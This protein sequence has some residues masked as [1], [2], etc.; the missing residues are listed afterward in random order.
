VESDPG[1]GS[2]FTVRLLQGLVIGAN[3]LGKDLTKKIGQLRPG[4]T[5]HIKKSPVIHEYMP[6]G[7]VLVVDD[8][9]TNL[10]VTRGLLT[11]YGLSV[12]TASSGYEAVEKVK[13]GASWDIIF[14]DHY[15]PGLDGIEAA[16]IIRGLGYKKHIVAL[17]ANVLTGQAEMFFANGFD[18][19]ISKPIDVRQLNAVLNKLIRDKYPIETVE[20][21]RK[22]KSSMGKSSAPQPSANSEIAKIFTRDAEKSIAI[23]EAIHEKRYNFTDE[24]IRSYVINVH[25]MKS[26]LANIGETKLSAIA[27]KL[28]E[29]GRQQN[30]AVISDE[31]P[32]F[33]TALRAVI[34]KINPHTNA[35]EDEVSLNIKDD[36]K[37]YLH[38]KLDVVQKA[39]SG[40]DKK[41]AKD[42]LAQLR[43]KAWPH[44]VTELLEKIAEHLLHSEF[45]EASNMA[46]DCKKV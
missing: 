43:Q 22:L 31:T 46:E 27:L 38:E 20:A 1:K 17:T 5:T 33:L 26:A 41:T 35:V 7:R 45:A 39:C 12:E 13:N 25:A 30:I 24:D 44:S 6:Y 2:E 28:E 40:Y 21:A 19:F 36:D 32:A 8:I 10:Y 23:L 34:E 18:D 9:E 14:M 29:A 3:I 11:P 37:A 42:A 16:K 15:M 4:R